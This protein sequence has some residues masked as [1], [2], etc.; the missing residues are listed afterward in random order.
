[1]R[2]RPPKQVYVCAGDK[3]LINIYHRRFVIFGV[4]CVFGEIHGY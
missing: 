4:M 3:Q 2:I 1:M